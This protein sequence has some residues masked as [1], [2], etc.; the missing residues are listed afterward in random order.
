MAAKRPSEVTAEQ[1][2][3][4]REQRPWTQQDLADRIRELGG[5]MDRAAIAKTETGRRGVSLD[6]ALLFA[7]ALNV[8]P[9]N[10]FVPRTGN[11]LLAVAPRREVP[12][13]AA[14]HWVRGEW[15]LAGDDERAFYAQGSDEDWI[16]LFNTGLFDVVRK[17]QALV[18]AAET[19]DRDEMRELVKD[20]NAAL[21]LYSR[22]LRHRPGVES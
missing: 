18:D 14:R 5:V 10:L 9:S 12:P 22:N 15:P 8:S 6:D 17:V 11:D 20:L 13:S 21:E 4:L 16:G 19:N 2:R 1:L 7:A 3:V